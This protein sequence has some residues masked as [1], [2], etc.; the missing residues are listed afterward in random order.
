MEA[1]LVDGLN[2][3][4][5][6]YAAVPAREGAPCGDDGGGENDGHLADGISSSVA[7]LRRALQQHDPS[8]CLVVFDGGRRHARARP[9]PD[10][11]EHP[12]PVL[13][14]LRRGPARYARALGGIHAW[15]F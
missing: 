15:R 8:H 12:Q 6:I 3:V 10:Y 2:L 7:S 14:P 5:R 4:R 9:H 1:L 13:P 11:K